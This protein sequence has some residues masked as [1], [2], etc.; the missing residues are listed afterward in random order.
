MLD[1]TMAQTD[2]RDYYITDYAALRSYNMTHEITGLVYFLI[3]V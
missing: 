1:E 2:A 3:H